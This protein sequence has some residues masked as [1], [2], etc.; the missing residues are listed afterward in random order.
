MTGKSQFFF[1]LL[2][3]V[4]APWSGLYSQGLSNVITNSSFTHIGADTWASGGTG[5][6]DVGNFTPALSN[7]ATA[8]YEGP[9]IYL[10]FCKW[11]APAN[12]TSSLTLL[13]SHLLSS[14]SP[15]YDHNHFSQTYIVMGVGYTF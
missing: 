9:V 1:L 5:V 10:E 4:L 8:R 7:P 13:D 6:A 15:M 2:P 12:I 3:A 14:N 11:K